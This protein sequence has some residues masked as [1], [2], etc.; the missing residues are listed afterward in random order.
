M[1]KIICSTTINPPTEAIEK[2]DLMSDWELI[3]MGDAKSPDEYKLTNGQYF[4]WQEQFKKYPD[5][6]RILGPNSVSRGR[7]LSYLEAVKQGA[8]IIATVDD[9]NIPLDNWGKD[10]V[11]G[12]EI[13]AVI[14]EPSSLA[15][16]PLYPYYNKS[17]NMWHRGFPLELLQHSFS[18]CLSKTV[19]KVVPAV[20]SNLW[21]GNPD[22]DAIYRLCY[23]NP[24]HFSFEE[25]KYIDDSNLNYYGTN[26][27]SPVNTQNTIIDA[28][29]IYKLPHVPF[30]GRVEDI[31]GGY[32]LQNEF[33]DTGFNGVIYGPPTVFQRRNEH[34]LMNDFRSELKGYM[35][36]FNLLR[37]MKSKNGFDQAN[38]FPTEAIVVLHKWRCQ[39]FQELE[40]NGK[41]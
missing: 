7:L 34:D 23:F 8:D 9:D 15:F 25:F 39:V 2:Y 26:V 16:D 38:Y 41:V 30:V 37:D 10:I 36:T 40:K 22:L 33:K 29:H 1:K 21:N 17:G 6:S 4:T 11:V 5:L 24:E 28:R 3:V 31:W 35:Q 20:Q 18:N 27:F 13:E 32:M 14:Y 12:K 19:K